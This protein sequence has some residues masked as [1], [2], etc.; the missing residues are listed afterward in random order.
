MNKVWGLLLLGCCLL[1]NRSAVAEE[2]T[3]F[4]GVSLLPNINF[5]LAEYDATKSQ[6]EQKELIGTT[7]GSFIV[8]AGLENDHWDILIHYYMTAM[9]SVWA[10]ISDTTWY[11]EYQHYGA[12]NYE[13]RD[14][15]ES[16]IAAG[17]RYFPRPP[18]VKRSRLY[19]GCGIGLGRVSYRE[20]HTLDYVM[21]DTETT[22]TVGAIKTESEYFFKQYGELGL[23]TKVSQNLNMIF[24]FTLQHAL[25][26]LDQKRLNPYIHNNTENWVA[27]LEFGILYYF[28]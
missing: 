4:I 1:S 24:G 20:R 25:V 18:S 2:W 17:V 26:P 12:D 28:R 23:A 27:A 8:K 7:N 6:K 5:V 21:E 10:D 19:L 13:F 9:P 11:R 14:W 15:K 16:H 22:S 3:P